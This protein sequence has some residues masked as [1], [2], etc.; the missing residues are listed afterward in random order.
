M[1]IIIFQLRIGEGSTATEGITDLYLNLLS[2]ILSA[3]MKLAMTEVLN[4]LA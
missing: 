2:A 1:I 3:I 4:E